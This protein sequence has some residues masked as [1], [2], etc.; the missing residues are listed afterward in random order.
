MSALPTVMLLADRLASTVA[1]A[2][3]ACDAAGPAPTG[4]RRPRHATTRPG[5]S[6]AAN[7]RPVPKGTRAPASAMRPP[8]ACSPGGEVA[9]LVELAVVGQE[10]LGHHAQHAAAV[11]RHR[12]VVEP[13]GVAQRRAHQ[14]QRQQ[15]G[16]A[17]R[18]AW[19]R[20]AP[21]RPAARPAAA[22]RRSRS[23]TGRAR[24]TPRPPRPRRGTRGRLQHG[25]GVARGVGQR[26]SAAC[27]RRRGRSPAHTG[28]GSSWRDHGTA[29]RRFPCGLGWDDQGRRDRDRATGLGHHSELAGRSR[30]WWAR[31]GL[32]L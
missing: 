19:R 14:Q 27:R 4:P 25:G 3:A 16:A 13:P 11:D 15:A 28:N 22:G 1:P 8:G 24:G 31:Q 32:N 29:A 18:H 9:A 12:A 2:S 17:L 10:A 5:T 20:R 6:S 30:G 26:C 7:S 21:P 23:R